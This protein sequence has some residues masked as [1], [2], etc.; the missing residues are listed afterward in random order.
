MKII[1]YP[2]KQNHLHTYLYFEKGRDIYLNKNKKQKRKKEK[3]KKK[4][5]KRKQT[6]FLYKLIKKMHYR[7]ILQQINKHQPT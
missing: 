3:T 6:L 2:I 1:I 5:Q 4:K 7:N